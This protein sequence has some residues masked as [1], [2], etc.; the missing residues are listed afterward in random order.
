MTGVKGHNK[1]PIG[2]LDPDQPPPYDPEIRREEFWDV[3]YI[4]TALRSMG[5]DISVVDF[6]YWAST[7]TGPAYTRGENNR[8]YQ[9]GTVL[10]FLK[11]AERRPELTRPEA[12][13]HLRSLGYDVTVDMLRQMA[14]GAGNG[15]PHQRRGKW[16]YYVIEELEKWARERKAPPKSFYAPRCYKP[17]DAVKR[18]PADYKLCGTVKHKKCE[19]YARALC[20][21]SHLRERP[22]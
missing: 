4:V 21:F 17:R 1:G 13:K 14:S 8:R 7:G 2:P 3:H 5:C 22:T 10:E 11:T 6:N 19:K 15:P 12:A 18:C 16:A 9:W 20:N